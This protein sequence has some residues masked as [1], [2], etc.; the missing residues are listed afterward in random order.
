MSSLSQ[1]VKNLAA[2]QKLAAIKQQLQLAVKAGAR[3]FLNGAIGKFE[4]LRSRLGH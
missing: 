4:S 3:K 2:E 1:S